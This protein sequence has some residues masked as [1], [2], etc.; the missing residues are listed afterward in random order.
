MNGKKAMRKAGVHFLHV[1]KTGGSSMKATIKRNQL[2]KL[3]DG[4]PLIPHGHPTTLPDVLAR[5]PENVAVFFLRDPVRRFV[6]G[7]NSRLR[8]GKPAK[9]IPWKPAE[10]MTFGYFPTAN[11]LA[12]AL[13]S[14]DPAVLDRAYAGINSMVHSRMHFTYW[15]HDV[16]YLAKRLERIAFIGFQEH[17][18]EDLT[19]FFEL[20]GVSSVRPETRHQ[21]PASQSTELSETA[22]RNLE[23][24]YADDIAIYQWALGQR[25][26][27]HS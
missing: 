20:M 1:G 10:R 4:R 24:W 9:S 2:R 16:D 22:V 12:E 6:S 14:D 26:R 21:A 15:F 23:Q 5:S 17:Y 7:F 27:W 25:D 18:D 13:S 11:D 3:P 8:E 19:R